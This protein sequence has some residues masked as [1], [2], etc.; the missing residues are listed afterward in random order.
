MVANGF[1]KMNDNVNKVNEIKYY[2]WEFT[3][4]PKYGSSIQ[5]CIEYYSKGEPIFEAYTLKP[6]KS[7]P[8]RE[9]VT[10][11]RNT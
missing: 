3:G 4:H 10:N 1:W 2:V 7:K 11:F 9:F 6:G 8:I 5:K